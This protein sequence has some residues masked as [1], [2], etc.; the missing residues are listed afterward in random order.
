MFFFSFD[1][2]QPSH[3]MV[4]SQTVPCKSS[5]K[6]RR[7]TRCRRATRRACACATTAGP[8][9]ASSPHSSNTHSSSNSSN[10]NNNSSNTKH[11][12]RAV[13]AMTKMGVEGA[14]GWRG[15]TQRRTTL[16]TSRDGWDSSVGWL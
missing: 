7:V 1:P 9:R 13:W 12:F 14:E 6:R 2:R 8:R 5:P 10:N 4:H 3:I 15:R 11:S 16:F